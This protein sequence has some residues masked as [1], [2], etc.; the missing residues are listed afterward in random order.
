MTLL[1]LFLI[2]LFSMTASAAPATV[3]FEHGGQMPEATNIVVGIACP[4]P[5]DSKFASLEPELV[6]YESENKAF[7]AAMAKR[8]D[9]HLTVDMTDATPAEALAWFQERAGLEPVRMLVIAVSCPAWGGDTDEEVFLMNGGTLPFSDLLS[10]AA[11]MASSSVWLFDASRNVTDVLGNGAASLGPT[12]DDA[13]KYGVLPDAL[14]ISSSAPGKYGAPGLIGAAA[15]AI[16][17]SAGKALTL[18]A[19]YHHGIKPMAPTLELFTSMG[20]VQDDQWDGNAKRPI[21]PG[22][23][24]HAAP[25][26][27]EAQQLLPL[28]VVKLQ[29]NGFRPRHGML[30]GGGASLIAGGVFAYQTSKE[31]GVLKELNAKGGTQPELDGAV[32]RYRTSSA[33]AIGLGTLGAITTG[34]GVTWTILDRTASMTLTPIDTGTGVAIS[35]TR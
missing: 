17:L 27:A 1:L 20:V 21:L 15:E 19:L 2:S 11:P 24:L 4:P 30:I 14:A 33:V 28:K 35:I 8:L 9:V 18:E 7:L 6:D 25:L 10:A 12:A 32:K 22:G 5:S 13:V 3:V 29:G 31:Y 23:G 26:T 16:D 34:T